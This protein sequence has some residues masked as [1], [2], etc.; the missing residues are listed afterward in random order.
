MWVMEWFNEGQLITQM[1]TGC[2]F[3]VLN[4]T[5][6]RYGVEE[7][8]RSVAV[9]CFTDAAV[10]SAIERHDLAILFIFHGMPNFLP[11][12]FIIS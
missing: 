6:D 10:I 4:E 5:T 12:V 2:L 11:Y 9:C 1:H 8:L 7:L 3:C